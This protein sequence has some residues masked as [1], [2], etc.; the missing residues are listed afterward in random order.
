MHLDGA[1]MDATQLLAGNPHG[2]QQKQGQ[3]EPRD[4]HWCGGKRATSSSDW[5]AR[6]TVRG[7]QVPGA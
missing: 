5:F 1:R 7:S 2:Q 4:S 6:L 3:A